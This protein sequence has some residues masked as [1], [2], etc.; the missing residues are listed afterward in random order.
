M[1]HSP[2]TRLAA[3][4]AAALVLSGAAALNTTA[5]DGSTTASPDAT[6]TIPWYTVDGGGGT[7]SAGIFTLQGTAGQPD[8]GVL[9]GGGYTL[10]GG[11][12]YAH[13]EQGI[14]LP[15]VTR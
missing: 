7:S 2:I 13:S 6:Y 15:L 8:A 4:L 14:W 5:Q 12:W 3:V 9:T 1:R 10:T 11:F